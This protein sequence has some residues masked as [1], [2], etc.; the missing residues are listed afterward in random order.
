MDELALHRDVDKAAKA[1]ALL[2]DPLLTEALSAIEEAAISVWRDTS[3]LEVAKRE[4]SWQSV[5]A[6]ERLRTKLKAHLD[7]GKLA[8]A[9]IDRDQAKRAALAARQAKR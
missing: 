9:E 4:N 8:Q 2:T 5:K 7:A 1:T 3:D 6:V